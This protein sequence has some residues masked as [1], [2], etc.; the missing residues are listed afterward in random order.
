MIPKIGD[1]VY[2]SNVQESRLVEIGRIQSLIQMSDVSDTLWK[3]WFS[4][5]QHDFE[6][7]DSHDAWYESLQCW[8]QDIDSARQLD[9]I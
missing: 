4:D 2:T 7:L 3:V 6:Y 8:I 9:L 5:C 1:S